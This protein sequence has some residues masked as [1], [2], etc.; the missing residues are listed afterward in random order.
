VLFVATLITG[1]TLSPA[2][3]LATRTDQ[4]SPYDIWL[5]PGLVRWVWGSPEILKLGLSITL[6]VLF[7]L[8][9]HELGHYVACRIYKLDTTPPYFLPAPI[10]FGSFGAFIRI[11]EPM[12]NRKELFDVGVAGPLAGF[13]ALVPWLV[14]GVAH[15][16][17][18]HVTI[19]SRANAVSEILTPGRSLAVQLA[20]LP[21]HGWLGRDVVLDLHPFALAALIGIF[22]T[23]INLLP[24]GQLD[25]GHIL[26][27]ASR[28][29]QHRAAWPLW[30]GLAAL[31]ILSQGWA[32][33]CALLLTMGVKHP[34]LREEAE[35]LGARRQALAIVA[36]VLFILCF[37]PIP[38]DDIYIR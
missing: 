25:G 38:F 2:F 24:V 14:Y 26:Y 11:R 8:L 31:A 29:W 18:V 5:S 30:A 15:S 35:P 20:A 1:T 4:T 10:G 27:A 17:P 36:L 33:W 16:T 22:A 12:R 9:C 21:F 37:A 32:L 3:Y 7:I 34:P 19:G 13:V 6:P 23:A 28:E